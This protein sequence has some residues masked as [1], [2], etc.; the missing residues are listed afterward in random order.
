MN[1]TYYN[2]C[3][4]CLSKILNRK[5]TKEKLK[6][7]KIKRTCYLCRRFL[8]NKE[9]TRRS[10][11]TYYSACKDCNKNVFAQ[12][13]RARM[14]NSKGEFSTKQWN[15]LLS[16]YESCPMCLRKWDEI[17][18]PSHLKSVI[19]RDHIVPIEKE[20]SNSIENIQPLCYSCNSK[21][22]NRIL[23]ER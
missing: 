21:K 20:G 12:R 8:P 22:G 23:V 7:T 18:K 19:T 9:F 14:K 15:E 17:P 6:H 3:R 5:K 11:S 16:Q 10:N 2:M 13:R 4:T 1:D